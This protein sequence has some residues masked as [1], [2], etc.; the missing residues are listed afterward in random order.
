MQTTIDNEN[1]DNPILHGLSGLLPDWMIRKYVSITPFAEGE[2]R[3][4]II[5]Y[6]LDSYGYSIRLGYK[7]KVFSNVNCA[8]VDPKNIDDKSFTSIDLTPIPH[9]WIKSE[10]PGF[11]CD[12][13]GCYE[14]Y[15]NES[16]T[17][18]KFYIKPTDLPKPDGGVCDPVPN[19]ILIPPNSF[20]LAETLEYFDVP[21][22]ILVVGI[23]KSTYAR[24]GI[25]LN[26]TPAEPEWKGKLTLEISNTT[27][28]PVKV[29]VGEGI[30]QLLFFR[31]LATCEKSYAD[32]ND[33]AGG[34]YQD[35]Q[36]LTLPR[37]Q[38]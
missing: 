32:R 16:S 31:T 15:C 26:V 13:P 6:G 12:N 27:P 21:R 10:G 34:I 24:C 29:Y 37:V 1:L 23:G 35:Q 5:S 33:G 19:H 28:L 4:G 11:Y 9:R 17:E 38:T 7:F 30:C 8:V 14:T 2:K 22:D 3:Q 20:A 18:G 25:I 36:G